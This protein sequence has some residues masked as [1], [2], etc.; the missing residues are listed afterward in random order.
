MALKKALLLV[1][2]AALFSGTTYAQDK[3]L[4]LDKKNA[5]SLKLGYHW[6]EESSVLDFW[7]FNEHDFNSARDIDDVVWA[8]GYEK[9][10]LSRLGIELSFGFY[11]AS[12]QSTSGSSLRITNIFVSPTAKFY[13]PLGDTFVLYAG[14]GVDFYNTK[15]KHSVISGYDRFNTFGFHGLGGVDW[16]IF[17]APE[18]HGFYSAPVSLFLEFQYTVLEIDDVDEREI[19][20]LLGPSTPKNDL[21]LGGLTLFLGL[22]WHY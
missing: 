12:G 7:N 10:I 6:F 9:L 22:R 8:F 21:D 2:G 15:W 1:V 4:H 14:G 18:K 16:Y 20:K 17:K 11:K 5:F 13:F 3:H 19:N